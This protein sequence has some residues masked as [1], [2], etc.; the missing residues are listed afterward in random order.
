[1]KDEYAVIAAIVVFG[2]LAMLGAAG[3]G[4]SFGHA[5]GA[6]QAVERTYTHE[7]LNAL[8]EVEMDVMAGTDA[9]AATIYLLPTSEDAK[10]VER[11]RERYGW[12]QGERTQL[13]KR[14][15]DLERR[16]WRMEN[17]PTPVPQEK[18]ENE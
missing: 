11:L 6:A 18:G 9:D 12:C 3:V 7:D 5:R 16:I 8:A 2:A 17:P 1:M 10:R 4:Y 15:R 13:E 14:I